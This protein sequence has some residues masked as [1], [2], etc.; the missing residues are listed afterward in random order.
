MTTAK[1]NGLNRKSR[2]LLRGWSLES[3]CL[4]ALGI[5]LAI[6]FVFAMFLMHWIADRLVR[7]T[8]RVAARNLALSVVVNRHMAAFAGNSQLGSGSDSPATL[9]SDGSLT[10]TE[11]NGDNQTL[12]NAMQSQLNLTGDDYVLFRVEDEREWNNLGGVIASNSIDLNALYELERDV[13]QQ[14]NSEADLLVAESETNP[15]TSSSNDRLAFRLSG[16]SAQAWPF[17][18]LGPANG[19]YYFYH[20]VQFN[21]QCMKCHSPK[22]MSDSSL[23]TTTSLPPFR[24]V[25]VRLP[26]ETTRV[27]TIWTYSSMIA[28]AVATLSIALFLEHRILKRLV[29]R[30]LLHLRDITDRVAGGELQIRSN[31]ETKDEFQTLSESLNHMLRNLID[32]QVNLEDA[33]EKLDDQVDQLARVNLELFEANRLKS[34]FLANMSHELRTPLNSILGFSDVLQAIDTLNDK[35]KR[36]A[37]NIQRSG[38]ILLDMINDILDLAKIEAGKMQVRCVEF[39]ITEVVNGQCEL[40]RSLSDEKNIDVRVNVDRPEDSNATVYQDK[41]KLQ[42]ILNNLLSNAIKFTPEGGFVTVEIDLASDETV[43]ISV[44]D[45]G[46]GIAKADQETIFEKFRQVRSKDSHDSL[47]REVT[48]TGLG[49]SITKELCRLLGGEIAVES[50]VGKGSTFVVDL[51]R[52]LQAAAMSN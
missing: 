28:V 19:Y 50:E 29:I 42:Q 46:V 16:P 22:A 12:L 26:Y 24:A 20:P 7:E 25:R 51:P 27:W 11:P 45:T 41:G 18:E 14:M 39:D 8:T 31:L 9:P 6:S 48:G 36:Y 44:I 10:E 40:I 35:Q 15:P 23:G 47:T 49:L 43:T 30:P 38:R 33:N 21:A 32:A 37:A 13:R 34:E 52:V 1:E 4:V 2:S 17:Q 3:K 5:S